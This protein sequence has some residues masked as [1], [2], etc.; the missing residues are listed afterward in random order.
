MSPKLTAFEIKE[1][2]PCFET[3]S[4]IFI[5]VVGELYFLPI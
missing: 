1:A 5:P 2:V 3:A 4:K